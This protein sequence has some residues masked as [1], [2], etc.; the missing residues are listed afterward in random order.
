MDQTGNNIVS[1]QIIDNINENFQHTSN[2]RT[3]NTILGT[4][5]TNT[6]TP[7]PPTPQNT[8]FEFYLPLPNDTRIYHVT[9]RELDSLE[10]G[11]LLNNSINLSH[12]PYYQFP[13]HYNVQSLIQQ[14]IV[15]PPIDYQQSTVQ[16]Q[17]FDTMRIQPVFQEYSGNNAYD[18]TLNSP[19]P[20]NGT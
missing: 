16:Q 7:A 1:S 10:I 15:Q 3:S 4:L 6:T 17:S 18:A 2:V 14:R 19:I 20:P 12:V 11:Q 5:H 9:Y 13:H 8:T